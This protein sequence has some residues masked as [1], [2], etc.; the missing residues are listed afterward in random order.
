MRYEYRCQGCPHQWEED[1]KRVEDDHSMCPKC[2]AQGK[3]VIAGGTSFVLK[4]GYTEK[5]GYSGG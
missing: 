3:R 1:D 5:N 4:G 2:Y